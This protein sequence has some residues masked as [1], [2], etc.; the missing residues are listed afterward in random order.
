MAPCKYKVWPAQADTNWVK[1]YCLKLFISAF[2]SSWWNP[3]SLLLHAPLC[4]QDTGGTQEKEE[5]AGDIT[6]LMIT[7]MPL[8]ITPTCHP[9]TW[10]E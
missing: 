5:H 1:L 4:I 8:S 3:A 2:D 7:L 10:E 6:I 9:N